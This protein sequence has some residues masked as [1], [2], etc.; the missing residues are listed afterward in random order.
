M[1]SRFHFEH[2]G[3]LHTVQV[4]RAGDG[5][6]V[7]VGDGDEAR[8][9]TVSAL[10]SERG[11]L[12][13]DVNGIRHLAHV[14]PGQGK[15]RDQRFVAVDGATWTLSVAQ[16]GARRQRSSRDARGDGSLTAG[17]P[18]QV[19][20][21]LV[22][23]GDVVEQGQTLVLLEAMKMELRITAPQAGTISGVF[24]Q[25]GE[26]VDRGQRLVEMG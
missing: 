24:C 19:L 14:A 2:D 20:D 7:S 5:W 21:V 10:A 16:P 6:T 9:Y 1:S 23:V 18:G 8:I 4:D 11:R 25:A 12:A 26:T 13:L 17:M 22:R 3:R 15:H